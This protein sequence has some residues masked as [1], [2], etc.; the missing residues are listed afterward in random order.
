LNSITPNAN[1]VSGRILAVFVVLITASGFTL[2]IKNSKQLSTETL[3]FMHLFAVA[4]MVILFGMTGLYLYGHRFYQDFFY[5]FLAVSWFGN[6]IYIALEAFFTP[7]PPD[8][9]HSLNTYGFSLLSFAPFYVASFVGP[10]RPPAYK[11]PCLELV[12]WFVWVTVSLL[13]AKHLTEKYW[14]TVGTDWRFMCYASGGV[15][16]NLWTLV[17]V[18]NSLKSRFNTQVHGRWAT[19]FPWTFYLYASLQPVYPLRFV[20]APPIITGVFCLALLI[21][22]VNS[23]S[24]ISVMQCDFSDLQERLKQ[25]SILED[26][27][28]LTASIEHDIKNPLQVMDNLIAGMKDRFQAN[29]EIVDSLRALEIEK[30]RIFAATQIIPALRGQQE[31]YERFMEKTSLGDLV[32]RSIKVVKQ[33]MLPQGIHFKANDTRVLYTRAYVPMLQQAV[34]NV[35]KNAVE[36]IHEA[37]RPNG[38]IDIALSDSHGSLPHVAVVIKDNGAGIAEEDIPKAKN[39]LFTTKKDKKPNSGI[40]L[41]ISDRILRFHRGHLDIESERG[42]GTTV[43]L[44]L[45]KWKAER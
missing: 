19:I 37:Q 40:G 38:L 44:V 32:H 11:R 7:T 14:P 45:P 39:T 15:P 10:D 24:A 42:K 34:V 22:I 29:S 4:S 30:R 25:R 2:L 12:G 27:G 3:T 36:A 43:S 9:R 31:F 20:A 26:L 5:S 17:R 23:A 16:F 33:E 6:A 13:L 35:L 18:G 28:I 1:S 41:F 8:L 21:K